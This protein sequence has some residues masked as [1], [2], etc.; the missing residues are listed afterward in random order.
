MCILNLVFPSFLHSLIVSATFRVILWL[1][2]AGLTKLLKTVK[3]SC[4]STK[5]LFMYLRIRINS[6]CVTQGDQFALLLI[7]FVLLGDIITLVLII[8]SSF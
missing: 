3:T 5:I 1:R 7:V 6:T 8:H 2:T 4:N